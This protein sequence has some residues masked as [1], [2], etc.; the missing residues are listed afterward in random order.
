MK[1]DKPGIILLPHNHVTNE[2]L[3]LIFAYKFM[4]VDLQNIIT[5]PWLKKRRDIS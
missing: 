1:I 3:V 2:A 4:G 5:L